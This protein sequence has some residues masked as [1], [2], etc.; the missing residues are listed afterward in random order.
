MK[1]RILKER[2]IAFFLLLAAINLPSFDYMGSAVPIVNNLLRVLSVIGA[3]YMVIKKKK[4]KFTPLFV[5]LFLMR[6]ELLISTIMN[7]GSMWD[8]FASTCGMFAFVLI[9]EAWSYDIKELIF[10]LMPLAEL[11]CYGNYL[12]ILLFP[13]G[14]YLKQTDVG[15][16]TMQNWLLGYRTGFIGY[17][18]PTCLIAFIY[19]QFGGK[20]WREW[21]VYIVSFIAV[22]LPPSR[23]ATSAIGL[24]VF[25]LLLCIVRR[26]FK[27]N[28]Y[29]LVGINVALF[30][31]VVVF[32]LHEVFL[33]LIGQ[34]FVKNITTLSG[35]TDLWDNL[36]QLIKKKPLFG[37]G[38]QS[39]AAS[40]V[41]LRFNW[42]TNGHNLILHYLYQGGLI[43]LALYICMMVNIYKHLQKAQK[44]KTA[45]VV[46]AA[47]FVFQI[48]GLT[49]AYQ[50]PLMYLLYYFA[51]YA[52]QLSET[53]PSTVH[54]DRR[55]RRI[56]LIT[57]KEK[58]DLNGGR[59]C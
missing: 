37:C 23:S 28:V 52:K 41:L 39:D 58:P 4:G 34:I 30:F 17:L 50:H 11:L 8:W 48:M 20:R 51:Y 38:V 6:F 43:Q 14:M 5:Y 57:P 44:K 2:H 16:S 46:S 53:V 13:Q 32:R 29:L 49:E 24:T 47:L 27:I 15:W 42:G 59:K 19:R 54:N 25:F 9:F 7:A 1:I 18:L 31:T 3:G 21:G 12:T 40:T 10:G 36:F 22:A 33:G 56:A 26:G 45:Q 35:R 55:I